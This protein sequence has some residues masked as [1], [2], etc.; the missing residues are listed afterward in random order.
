MPAKRGARIQ[1]NI[2]SKVLQKLDM[3]EKGRRYS[4]YKLQAGFKKPLIKKIKIKN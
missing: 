2:P 3:G 4:L 1:L